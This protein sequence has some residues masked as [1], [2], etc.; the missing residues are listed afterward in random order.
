MYS[1]KTKIKYISVLRHHDNGQLRSL[2]TELTVRLRARD[3]GGEIHDVHLVKALQTPAFTKLYKC[4]LS[5]KK[6][7]KK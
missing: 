1:G 4:K 5:K 6:K 2:A 7:K 3:V